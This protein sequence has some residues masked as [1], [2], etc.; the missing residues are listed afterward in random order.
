MPDSLRPRTSR[1]SSYAAASPAQ[2]RLWFEDSVRRRDG[3]SAAYHSALSLRI[4]TEVDSC[5]LRSAL[6]LVQDRHS[7][8]RTV[9]E[10]ADGELFQRVVPSAECPLPV[11]EV[12]ADSGEEAQSE[13]ERLMRAEFEKPFDL[14][15][16]PMLR[17]RLYRLAPAEYELQLVVHHIATD[18]WSMDILLRELSDAYAA[19]REGETPELP[20]LPLQYTDYTVWLH[21]QVESGGY[22]K[23]LDYW[24]A[25]LAGAPK[26]LELPTDRPRPAE[27]TY[28]TGRVPYALPQE[29]A[30][31]AAEFARDHRVSLYTLLLT[32]FQV[33][34]SRWT[35]RQEVV[36]GTPVANRTLPDTDRLIGFFVNLLPMRLVTDETLSFAELLTR[37]RTVT[38]DAYDHDVIAFDRLVDVVAPERTLAHAPIFQVLF[39]VA[40]PHHGGPRALGEPTYVDYGA[41]SHFDL[42]LVAETHGEKIVV[43][44]DYAR[45]LFDRS[46]VEL[47]LGRFRA[48]LESAMAE[49]G[50]ALVTL[51]AMPSEER[52]LID[53]AAVGRPLPQDRPLVDRIREAG[54]ERMDEIAI[55]DG[56][57]LVTYRELHERSDRLAVQLRAHGVGPDQVVAVCLPRG[58]GLIVSLVAIFKAGGAYLPIDP[59]HP[60]DRLRYM[61]E[62]SGARV[63]VSGAAHLGPAFPEGLP[64]LDIDN[65]PEAAAEAATGTGPWPEVHPDHLAW[66]IYTSGST[67]L[68]KGVQ[69]PHR[70]ATNCIRWYVDEYAITPEDRLSQLVASSSD[71][72]LL[73]ML[74]ALSAG[75]RIVVIPDDVRLDFDGLWAYFA[76]TGVTVSFMITPTLTASAGSAPA[77]HP[78]LTRLTVGGD[79][80]PAVP[81][82]LPCPLANIYGPT[83][84]SIAAAAGWLTSG[85]PSH[86]GNALANTRTYVLDEWLR[87]VPPG[88]NGE[89]YLAGPQLARG[90]GGRPGLTA[91]KFLPDV[92]AADGG[93]MYR[94]GDQVRWTSDGRLDFLG[95]VDRQVKVRG[96]R[97]ELE[98]IEQVISAVPGMDEVVVLLKENLPTGPGLVAYCRL[99]QGAAEDRAW[100]EEV[101]R[102]LSENLPEHMAPQGYVGLSRF[103]FNQNGKIDRPALLALEVPRDSGGEAG[104]VAPQGALQELVAE[105][106]RDVLGVE[107]VWANDNFFHLGGHSLLIV[108][109]VARLEAALDVK[110][111][112][113]LL[114]E[115]PVLS[116]LAQ[117]LEETVLEH[118]A[119]QSGRE[120]VR[121]A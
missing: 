98:E 110:I 19:I 75:A 101:R 119:S 116:D 120:G 105:V 64:V 67:G 28:R 25:Q 45:D 93:R 113:T 107:G 27:Q 95:R 63:V 33:T 37:A 6:T 42:T 22:D 72:S 26:L 11:I 97:I 80:L 23:D 100:I 21:G 52:T 85:V 1:A 2:R 70:G 91:K 36:I 83:E 57:D 7:V 24:T 49:P 114:F 109:A 5:S 81:D 86:V 44:T 79:R 68:P 38:L 121:P 32:A 53:T 65:V 61:I 48:V 14:G 87:P 112:L 71:A 35:G 29:L 92:I 8:L 10:L 20:E 51:P 43:W 111:R 84:A 118:L 89:L 103:P 15:A 4:R 104:H 13:L 60:A 115:C 102:H 58:A 106:W 31:R 108:K 56:D 16:D 17:A 74:P 82:G 3:R 39:S 9:L 90:Y 76:Q 41:E 18:G 46:T 30:A 99:A 54:A 69:V 40:D 66:L 50:A 73:D 117:R 47:L 62:D 12:T 34:L 77:T 55:A 96:F 88:V 59:S 94:T 78:T